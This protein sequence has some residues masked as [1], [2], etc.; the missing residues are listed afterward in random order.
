M[1]MWRSGKRVRKMGSPPDTGSNDLGQVT[2]SSNLA[3]LL[4]GVKLLESPS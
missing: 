3:M 1:S 2:A 4:N